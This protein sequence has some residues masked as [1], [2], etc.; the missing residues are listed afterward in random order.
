MWV[1]KIQRCFDAIA[2]DQTWPHHTHTHTQTHT[3]QNPII[4]LQKSLQWKGKRMWSSSYCIS[5]SLIAI[6]RNKH[7]MHMHAQREALHIWS[8]MES[9]KDASAYMHCVSLFAYLDPLSLAD[10]PELFL[11]SSVCSPYGLKKFLTRCARNT[12]ATRLR[13][14][15]LTL[16]QRDK[17]QRYIS[18]LTK[19]LLKT[20]LCKVFVNS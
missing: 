20:R 5:F 18:D 17:N 16:V 9:D 13:I 6:F 8:F 3:K 2:W 4:V 11:S 15:P 12:A 7:N 14:H 19:F 1:T 10:V